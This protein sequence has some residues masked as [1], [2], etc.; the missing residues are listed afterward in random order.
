MSAL[1]K[2]EDELSAAM[3]HG[4]IGDVLGLQPQCEKNLVVLLRFV[5]NMDVLAQDALEMLEQSGDAKAEAVR[6]DI[7][8][9]Y[10]ER[11]DADIES[12]REINSRPQT[13]L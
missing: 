2:F 10:A 13:N 6:A 4:T 5:P 7:E 8:T 3:L 11:I 9:R 12:M 1:K